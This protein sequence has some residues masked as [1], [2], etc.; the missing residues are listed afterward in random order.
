MSHTLALA[1]FGWSHLQSATCTAIL[2]GDFCEG[3]KVAVGCG[4]LCRSL[5][6]IAGSVGGRDV[7]SGIALLLIMTNYRNQVYGA[8]IAPL[9]AVIS[10]RANFRLLP[11]SCFGVVLN[12]ISRHGSNTAVV[13]QR[14]NCRRALPFDFDAARFRRSHHLDTGAPRGVVRWRPSVAILN[15]HR[16]YRH[17][18]YPNRD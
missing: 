18:I 5:L 3:T 2:R 8:R 6:T 4:P 15:L 11:G 13:A 16:S 10:N 17:R 1:S 14:G 12:S 7:S 9:G